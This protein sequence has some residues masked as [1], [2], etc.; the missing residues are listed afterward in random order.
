MLLEVAPGTLEFGLNHVRHKGQNHQLAMDMLQRRPRRKADVLEQD[1]MPQLAVTGPMPQP[2]TV[3][4]S[5]G[6]S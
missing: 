1:G 2:V 5:N 4:T 6:K 3:N